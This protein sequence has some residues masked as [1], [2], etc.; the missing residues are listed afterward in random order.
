MTDDILLVASGDLRLSANR[1]CWPAQQQLEAMVTRA[2][3][4]L[5]RRVV[6]AHPVEAAKGHGFLDSQARGIEIIVDIFRQI[7]PD[8]TFVQTQAGR[9]LAGNL[10]KILRLQAVVARLLKHC[11]QIE[12]RGRV[13]QR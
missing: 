11:R 6:R 9:P 12:G 7:S 8:F 13:L 1:V 4:E 3:A 10:I 5:G 2:F